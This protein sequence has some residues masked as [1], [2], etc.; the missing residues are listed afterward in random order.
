VRLRPGSA[1]GPAGRGAENPSRVQALRTLHWGRILPDGA[2]DDTL[3]LRIALAAW[4]SADWNA[5][6]GRP[7]SGDINAFVLALARS[8]RIFREFEGAFGALGLTVEPAAVEKVLVSPAGVLPFA[9][10]LAKSGVRAGD[11]VPWDAQL[12]L[13]IRPRGPS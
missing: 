8:G 10:A 13:S 2:A 9:D 4:R 6:T 1:P 11:T 7:R 12:W 3:A 5:K